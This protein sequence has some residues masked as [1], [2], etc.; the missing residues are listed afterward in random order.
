[1]S[2]TVIHI[3]TRKGMFVVKGS[4]EQARISETH[5]LGD[6]VVRTLVD[7]RD[8]TWYAVLDHGHFG[9][10]LHR[11]D[12]RGGAWEEVSVPSYPAKPEGFVDIDMWGKEREWALMCIWALEAALDKPGAL[13]CGTSPGGLFRSEDRGE[14]WTLIESLWNDETRPRWNG[15]G[16]D[17]PAIHSICV[18]PRDPKTVVIAVSSGGVWRTTDLGATWTSHTKGMIVSHV[19]PEQAE[20]PENQDAHCVVQSPTDPHVFWCQHHMGIWRSSND[21]ESWDELHPQPSSF[22]FPVAVDPTDADTAWF[23]PA[24]SDQKRATIDGR[25][26]VNRTRDGGQSFEALT[27]GLPQVHAYDLTLRHAL[28]ISRDGDSL[29]FGTTSGNVWVTANKGDQWHLLTS[30]LPPVYSVRFT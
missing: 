3:G 16:L 10:K 14:T 30:N 7:R 24:H 12:N 13:W 18:D 6:S 17:Q 8:G 9:V 4:G 11:S 22:G 27:Q 20:L 15:G 1:M 2:N 26:I 5:F 25:V 19:P 28:D 23:V 21:L 29:A